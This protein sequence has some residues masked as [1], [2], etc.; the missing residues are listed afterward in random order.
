MQR[1]LFT[2]EPDISHG[3]H[4]PTSAAAHDA[5]APHKPTLRRQVLNFIAAQGEH[6]ATLDEVC[7]ALG[8]LPHSLSGRITELQI[9]ESIRDSGRR[10]DTLAGHTATVWVA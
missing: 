5:I 8:K 10:R 3:R 2:P 1:D 6:G 4:A 9:D 7:R